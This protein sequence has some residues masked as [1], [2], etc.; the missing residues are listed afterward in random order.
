MEW[1]AVIFDLDGLMI[2]SEP[3]ALEVW[4]DLA[5]QYGREVSQ[6]L[7]RE[8]I[9]QTPLF[10]MRHLR[11]ELDLP[12]GE[13]ELLEEYWTRRTRMMCEKVQLAPG[14][15]ELLDLLKEHDVVMAVA[16]N[17]PCAYIEAVL[18]GLGLARFFDC[19]LSSDDVQKGKPAPD[20][21]T[22]TMECLGIE[23][24]EGL[25]LEDS[26]AGVCAAKSAGLTCFA[27]PSEEMILEDFSEADEILNSLVD[28][29][30][31][32]EVL[33]EQDRN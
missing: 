27:V 33:F 1:S 12:L 15:I 6:D 11:A 21:Y 30:Q 10:G 22:A 26:P 20:V 24:G 16:S 19:V 4:R 32:F 7:Y 25:V 3:I 8:V 31:R 23:P 14:L 2:D 17:S 29:V 13:N 18:E 9:G 5:A 28:V